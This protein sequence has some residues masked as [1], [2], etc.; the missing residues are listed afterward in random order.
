MSAV[1]GRVAQLW[2]YPVKSMAPEPLTTATLSW[3]G[4]AGDRRWA[5]V[6]GDRPRSGFPWLTLRE[7]PALDQ[8]VPCLVEPDRPDDSPVE[9]RTP[10]GRVLDVADPQLAAALGDGARAMKC[11]RGLFDAMPLS[12]L[13]TR[14]L[15]S[16]G[17]IVGAELDV[18]R[19]RPNLVIELDD[20]DERFPEEGWI[21]A[22]L[23]IGEA[24]IRVDARDQR[25]RI[26]GIDPLTSEE[27]PS[28]L[29]AI[30]QERDARFGVYGS[31]VRPGTVAVGDPVALGS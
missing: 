22:E 11:D 13:T 19:F 28:I 7:L 5:F 4:L 14:S 8:Y 18:R 10:D 26:V 2:R 21:G 12:V 23:Q 20:P 1:F 17:A 30:A 6:R 16:L 3:H 25:C 29:R 9:I 31:T 15:G 27:D 24:R